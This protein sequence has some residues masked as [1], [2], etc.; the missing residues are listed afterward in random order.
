MATTTTNLNLIKPDGSDKIRIANF[1]QN[2]DILDA[3]IGPVGSTSLQAQ[4][5]PIAAK[6]ATLDKLI[7]NGTDLNSLLTTGV[8]RSPNIAA[9]VNTLL[10]CPVEVPFV[11]VVSG[12]GELTGCVQLLC[13]GS[14]LYCR[15]ATSSGFPESW[16]S[17]TGGEGGGGSESE[18]TIDDLYEAIDDAMQNTKADIVDEL[19]DDEAG[20]GDDD[21][22]WSADRS[23]RVIRDVTTNEIIDNFKAGKYINCSGET[24]DITAEV[25]STTSFGYVVRDAAE[26]DKFT[27][28]SNGGQSPRSWCFIDSSGNVLDVA[29]ENAVCEDLVITAPENTAKLIINA[30]ASDG[31]SFTGIRISRSI[32]DLVQRMNDLYTISGNVRYYDFEGKHSYI[33]STASKIKVVQNGNQLH[34]YNTSPTAET[35][36]NKNRYYRLNNGISFS[37]ATVYTNADLVFPIT[38]GHK[39]RW[40]AVKYSGSVTASDSTSALLAFVKLSSTT[41]PIDLTTLVDYDYVDFVADEALVNFYIRT[42]NG[43]LCN[44]LKI[45]LYLIDLTEANYISYLIDDEAGEGATDRTW[46]ADK[47]SGVAFNDGNYDEMTVGNAKQLVASVGVEERMPYSFRESGG[48]ANIGDRLVDKLVG[49]TIGWNQLVENGNF[50]DLTGW[51]TDGSVVASVSNNVCSITVTSG[52]KNKIYR[53]IPSIPAE[54]VIL[55]AADIMLTGSVSVRFGVDDEIAL[56]SGDGSRLI[57]VSVYPINIWHHVGGIFKF[58]EANT[59]VNFGSLSSVTS[60]N[61]GTWNIKNFQVF[62]LTMMFGTTI[63][64]YMLSLGHVDSLAMFDKLFPKEYYAYNAGVLRS[65]NVAS[66]KMVG[67]NAFKLSDNAAK[68]VGGK[69]YQITGA[70]TALVLGTETITPDSNGYFT[71][72]SSGVL[73]VTEGNSTTC[74]HLVWDGERD[75]EFEEYTEYEYPIGDVDLYGTLQ[76]DE[77]H[78]LYCDGD[79]YESDGTV[80]RKFGIVDLGSLTW[81]KYTGGSTYTQTFFLA[82]ITGIRRVAKTAQVYMLM[83]NKYVEVY[84]RT[85]GGSGGYGNEELDKT[86]CKVSDNNSNVMIQDSAYSS[87]TSAEFKE[88][89]SGVMLLYELAE[90]T[91]EST[92]PY[93]NPQFVDDFGTEEYVDRRVLAG[94]SDAPVP[95][96]HETIYQANLRAKL[97]M[98]PDSPGDGDG[99]YIVRQT[100]GVNE[101]VKLVIPNELPSTPE[102]DGTYVLKVTV[103]NGTPTLSWVQST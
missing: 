93:Q 60:S 37:T 1:N 80:T 95:V 72:N 17:P 94:T 50:A 48:A 2:A 25:T 24:V 20:I 45:G 18:Y 46:S 5:T 3:K 44:D 21:V 7:E 13:S 51:S 81:T 56:R 101:Y 70:Y 34:L 29:P 27:I 4:V 39:Y 33:V 73:S 102:T 66:H 96:G 14:Q 77:N 8:Y 41:K 11:L 43:I 69:Q 19:F 84:S 68:V 67:F 79:T 88:A 52:T 59:Y 91:T 97:E 83:C 58:N 12:T 65:V 40:L 10:N 89:V 26:G 63:A 55:V 92:D 82:S 103:S 53:S 28:N 31:P 87:N 90:S 38:I 36:S 71:P 15:R 64:D 61:A 74:I 6:V 49:C 35:T 32:D 98:S 16:S 100:S 23:S 57:T 76:M 85:M 30:L 62:D 42:N 9:G 75:D 54:H 86:I 99:D 47:L 22:T 78:N